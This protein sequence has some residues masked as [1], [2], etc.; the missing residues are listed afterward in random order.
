MAPEKSRVERG[1]EKEM[2]EQSKGRRAFC[3]DEVDDDD[4]DSLVA[5]GPTGSWRYYGVRWNQLDCG[6]RY[7]EASDNM[8][9]P[10]SQVRR[11]WSS[12]SWR[13]VHQHKTPVK[14]AIP[15]VHFLPPPKSAV[16]TADSRVPVTPPS[17]RLLSPSFPGSR[18]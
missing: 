17:G 4:D 10:L 6:V 8:C 12:C 11:E 2:R 9:T 7:G 18:A 5:C 15:L 13:H 16:C 1:E 14:L 3:S